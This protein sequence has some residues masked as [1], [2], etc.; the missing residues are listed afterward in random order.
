MLLGIDDDTHQE[1]DIGKEIETV[2]MYVLC[3]D[4]DEGSGWESDR[5]GKWN[6][7]PILS[8]TWN[9]M[10]IPHPD[11]WKPQ[12]IK[13]PKSGVS[14]AKY[15]VD[16]SEVRC[17]IYRVSPMIG[18]QGEK[19]GG[20]RTGWMLE[21][22]H[23]NEYTKSMTGGAWIGWGPKRG[24]TEWDRLRRKW[25]FFDNSP[26]GINNIKAAYS[27]SVAFGPLWRARI[28]LAGLKDT[29]IDMPLPDLEAARRLM[30]LRDTIPGQRR[31]ALL[32]WVREHHR[33]TPSG[34][35]TTVQE[36]LRGD[37]E[38]IKVDDFRISLQ[39]AAISKSAFKQWKESRSRRGR[40]KKR[41]RRK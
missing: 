26:E 38:E 8:N 4:P 6:A 10:A 36:H 31:K 9:G 3:R 12:Q 23:V 28:S 1:V 30:R 34:G 40:S 17:E 20:I 14:Y 39:P 22:V 13:L 11:M 15:V 29:S 5:I 33:R 41:R 27:L 37:G 21:A 16:G 35:L 18:P 25:N 7:Y 19:V 24:W 2:L 32:H